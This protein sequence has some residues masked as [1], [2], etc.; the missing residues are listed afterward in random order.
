[1]SS[2]RLLPHVG[3]VAGRLDVDLCR[4]T[5]AVMESIMRTREAKFRRLGIDSVAEYRRRRSAGDP[6]LADDPFGDVFLVVDGW[7]TLR[8]EFDGLEGSI[9]ALAAQGLSFGVH[10]EVAAGPQG[11]DRYPHRTA[12]R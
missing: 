5:V 10:V 6:D 7:A 11:P 12:A 3:S 4:R 2:L 1:M 9:T 8:Q